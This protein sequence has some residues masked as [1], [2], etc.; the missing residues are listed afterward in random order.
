[1]VTTHLVL[2]TLV[3]SHFNIVILGYKPSDR[4]LNSTDKCIETAVISVTRQTIKLQL[5]VKCKCYIACFKW[6]MGRFRHAVVF[7]FVF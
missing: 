7:G 6:I 1:M 3:R 2:Y 4:K 5:T